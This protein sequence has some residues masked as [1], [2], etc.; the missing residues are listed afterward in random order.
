M[1]MRELIAPG[2][3]EMP[4]SAAF[5]EKWR[6]GFASY[7]KGETPDPPACNYAN[8]FPMLPEARRPTFRASLEKGGQNRPVVLFRG[9]ILDGRNRARELIELNKPIA[10]VIFTGRSRQ[11]LDFVIDEN[12]ERR[13]LTDKDRAGIAAKIANLRIGDNQHTRVVAPPNGGGSAPSLLP[14]LR[15]ETPAKPDISQEEAAALMHVSL[16]SV[17]RAAVIEKRGV[18]ELKE[19]VASGPV[20]LAAGAEIARLPVEEQKRILAQPE[21]QKAVK[22]VA[23]RNRAEKQAKSRER[24]LDNMRKPGSLELI[25][26]RKYGVHLF[27]VPREFVSWSDAT[28]A[29]KSPQNHYRVEG[30]Q[31]LADLR[32][33]ILACSAPNCVAVMWAWANSLQDQ[34]DLLIEWGFAAA[35]R[36]DESGL[37]LR[38]AD[39]RI[40]PPAGE[41][42][43]RSHQIWA[44]RNADGSLHRGTGFWFIDGH[45]LLLW[46]ARGDVPAPLPGTQAPSLLDL[47]IGDHSQKP[48][49]A[50]R[51]Q[52]DRYFPGVPKLEWFGRVPD[53]AAFK[54]RHPDW[55][56]TGNEVAGVAE[57]QR[58]AAE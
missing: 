21:L 53:L 56:V 38:D 32:T 45:E 54:A 1:N 41:G 48:G 5:Y 37:L 13:D 29:E 40:L 3:T 10:Y 2:G 11:A 34:L 46:G 26:S 24:R 18:P 58:E 4:G 22:E 42:R 33:K 31:Y 27:D 35:R 17:E 47:P 23:K 55:D 25:E 16:R 6:A 50:I 36:R 19:A 44:K 7:A 12:L 49:E 28:G 20:S 15:E 43:Y 8:M 39:A 14:E 30:L 57:S 9:M 51:D 52:I